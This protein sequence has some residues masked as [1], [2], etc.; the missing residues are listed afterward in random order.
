MDKNQAE[1]QQMEAIPEVPTN[2]TSIATTGNTNKEERNIPQQLLIETEA[3]QTKGPQTPN[4]KA[5]L[6]S[7][8]VIDIKDFEAVNMEEK[9]NLIMVAINKVNTN[10]HHKF[11]ELHNALNNKDD[12]IITRLNNCE[13]ALSDLDPILNDEEDGVLPRLREAE[14]DIEIMKTQ[15]DEVLESNRTLQDQVF[16]LSGTI[17]VHDHQI[18]SNEKKVT[19]LT[20]RSMANNILI[21]GLTGDVEKENCKQKVMEFLTDTLKMQ[22]IGEQV[23][24]AHRLGKKIPGKLRQMVVRCSPH[25]RR[26]VFDYTKKLKGIKN[27]QDRAYSVVPQYPEPIVTHRKEMR[28][29][30]IELKKL[31]ES[32][33]EEAKKI[34]FEIKQGQLVINGKPKKQHIYPPTVQEMYNIDEQEFIKI[35]KIKL[36]PSETITEKSSAFTGYAANIQNSTDIKLAYKKVKLMHPEADHLMIAYTLKQHVG[37]HDCGEH[38]ASKRLAAILKD[39][40]TKNTVVFVAR[41]YG[42][43]PLGP[44]RFLHI[45]KVARNALN[46]L[47]ELQNPKNFQG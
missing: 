23:I 45:E 14:S 38:G 6:E 3:R 26:T 36:V 37:R 27:D 32:I 22:N 2:D 41:T 29:E 10:F 7:K 11:Q 21:G 42:G 17:Q 43:I 12:G 13:N 30:I 34:K 24:V 25:L 8:V 46:N 31:N 18:Q 19:D 5:K 47:Q 4:P 20:K 40:N 1:P 39:R 9:L 44:R 35:D 33:Q 28:E 16:M 15:M